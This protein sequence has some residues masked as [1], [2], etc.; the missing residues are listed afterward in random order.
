MQPAWKS[1]L[2]H[3]WSSCYSEACWKEAAISRTS[4][5]DTH[6]TL[7]QLKSVATIENRNQ[8]VYAVISP[9]P[10][11]RVFHQQ[12]TD[13]WS[14]AYLKG[15]TLFLITEY[16]CDE[17]PTCDDWQIVP[18]AHCLS[19]KSVHLFFCFNICLLY[20]IHVWLHPAGVSTAL[21]F[22]S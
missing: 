5:K 13:V 10:S 16:F 9:A 11:A 22:F 3:L 14:E 8:C 12:E 20:W 17:D 2:R 7:I 15:N 4:F 6:A 21:T 18:V 1:R 19:L